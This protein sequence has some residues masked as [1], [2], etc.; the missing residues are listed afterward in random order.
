MTTPKSIIKALWNMLIEH[1]T[2]DDAA[3]IHEL[4]QCAY[5]TEAAIYN[6]FNIPPLLETLDQLQN[7]FGSKL[8]LKAV[9]NTQIV[10]SV[11]AFQKERTCYVERLIV[12]PDRRRQG[13]GSAL[14]REIEGE[15]PDA[16]RFEL[17]T[18]DKSVGNIRLYE[19]H[20]YRPFCRELVNANLTL[21]FL[22]KIVRT[23]E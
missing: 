18:G 12:H 9:E 4:Q 17:F 13:I 7:F 14:L 6:D 21:V 1:A 10:G 3:A 5:R 8:F 20:G 11:R 16:E 15:Y 2:A 22:E 23:H 19:H